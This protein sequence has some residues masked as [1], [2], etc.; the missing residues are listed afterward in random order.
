VGGTKP[1]GVRAII[2]LI[3]GQNI[4]TRRI[5]DASAKA[6]CSGRPEA[7]GILRSSFVHP[8]Y[9][10]RTSLLDHFHLELGTF[11]VVGSKASTGSGLFPI[12]RFIR[13]RLGSEQQP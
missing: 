9:T 13:T 11:A 6:P 3:G 12:G 5:T 4:A 7:S 1:G 2:A 8:S 10:L